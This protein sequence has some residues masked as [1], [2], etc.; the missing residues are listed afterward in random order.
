LDYV[1]DNK[2]ITLDFY[3]QLSIAYAG[4]GNTQKTQEFLEMANQLKK[5]AN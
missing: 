1:I 2:I 5:A 3:E 4:L